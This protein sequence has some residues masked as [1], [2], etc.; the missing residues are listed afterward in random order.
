MTAKTSA[1]ASVIF[2][3]LRLTPALFSLV[4][5]PLPGDPEQAGIIIGRLLSLTA[6]LLMW[7]LTESVFMLY[8]K[9][10][11]QE[12]S[13]ARGYGIVAALCAVCVLALFAP[14]R[15]RGT[16]AL[17]LLL[18][19]VLS[20]RGMARAGWGQGR[21]RVA[22][23]ATFGAHSLLALT[24]L[25]CGLPATPLQ[26]ATM[27]VT[28][29]AALA[30]GAALTAVELAA[31]HQLLAPRATARIA[32]P[33]F[34]ITLVIGPLLVSSLAMSGLLPG[35]YNSVN[36]ALFLAVPLLQ[37]LSRSGTAVPANITGAAAVYALFV[38]IL[39]ACRYA[40]TM[41]LSS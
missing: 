4:L 31:H 38:G 10:K 29:V 26:G 39:V 18:L 3:L 12:P 11:L 33:L 30:V 22:M 27:A 15:I 20:L 24:S 21:L 28:V 8:V 25:L 2:A 9:K 40:A 37:R 36:A 35:M 23:F 5:V 17:F 14:F 1:A 32:G 13:A 6:I 16:Q 41:A 7:N 19:G 34:R